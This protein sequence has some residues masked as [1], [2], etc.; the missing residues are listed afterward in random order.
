MASILFIYF[1]SGATV[2][3]TSQQPEHFIWDVSA[4]ESKVGILSLI[5]VQAKW[6]TLASEH[7]AFLLSTLEVDLHNLAFHSYWEAHLKWE[8]ISPLSHG[9]GALSGET[10][11]FEFVCFFP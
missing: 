4:K 10:G 9:E 1:F 3:I 11:G 5:I 7:D 8:A 2:P 6:R